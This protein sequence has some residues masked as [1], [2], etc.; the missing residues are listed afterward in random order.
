MFNNTHG[1]EDQEYSKYIEAIM[2]NLK[3]GNRENIE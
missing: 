1:H 2:Q 3:E